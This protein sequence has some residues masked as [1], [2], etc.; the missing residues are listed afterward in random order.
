MV[1]A[2]LSMLIAAY[3]CREPL[4]DWAVD[5]T[6]FNAEIRAAAVKHKLDPE[7]VRAVVFQESRFNPSCRGGQGEIGLMQLLPRGAVAEY[8]RRNAVPLPSETQLFAPALNLEIGCWYLGQAMRRWEGYRDQVSLALAQYN[9]GESR[10]VRWKPE[11]PE[12]PFAGRIG[13]GSTR[14]YVERITKRYARYRTQKE[15]GK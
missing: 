11:R 6:L 7:L 12:D 4:R 10:V 3:V 2:L 15:K 1:L 5:D 9:A 13:I 8:A 14:I